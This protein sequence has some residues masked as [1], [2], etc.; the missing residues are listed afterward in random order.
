MKALKSMGSILLALAGG[1]LIILGLMYLFQNQLLFMP[2]SGMMQTPQSVGL[3]AEDVWIETEDG[4]TIHGWYFPHDESEFVVVLSHG[5]AG[6]ISGRIAIAET[7]LNCGA[8]VLMY[9]YRGYGQSEGR[10]GEKGLYR[11]IEAVVETLKT[12]FD[13]S[14]RQIVM[15]GRS[16]GGAVAAYA[17][18]QFDLGGLVLDSAFKNL[19]AMIRDVYPFVP[20]W[21]AKYD[22]PT[23][24]YLGQIDGL[25]IMIM[26]SP[27]DEIVGFHHGRALFDLIEEPKRFV[28][29]RGGH[30]D[31]F[32]ASTDI[33]EENWR[34]YLEEARRVAAAKRER[35]DL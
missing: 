28:E 35:E 14:E 20:V 11:D 1:Y 5:N 7:L 6:N 25:P 33:I 24:K 32:F 30:N 27:N 19:K 8:S 26:H 16:L 22:F 10:P 18:V 31:N 2:S 13:Y 21:L 23:D 4:V 3:T 12:D 17:A 34:W 9:D 15:Y 29:L